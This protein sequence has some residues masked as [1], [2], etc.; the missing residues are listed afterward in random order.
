[1]VPPKPDFL[2]PESEGNFRDMV[3]PTQLPTNFIVM[4]KANT[5]RN[6]ET[7]GI[8]CGTL[9]HNVL[10]VTHLLIPKQTSTSDTCSTTNEED[11][12]DYQDKNNLI[13]MGWIHTHP[14]QSCFMSSVDL[15][16]HCS[17]Q[18]MLPEAVA[19]VCAPSANPSLG[20]FRLTDPPGLQ[21]ITNCREK[22]FHPHRL[23]DN[24]LYM[25]GLGQSSLRLQDVEFKIKDFR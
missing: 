23:S 16:T 10:R 12:F 9:Q 14:T 2:S 4:A 20:I 25:D 24:E 15:H 3:I 18:L 22:S 8:L 5:L 1:M 21:F 17:Y 13:T 6:M 19:I 7:C 11:I